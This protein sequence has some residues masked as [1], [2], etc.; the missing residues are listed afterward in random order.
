[1]KFRLFV[2]CDLLE[3]AVLFLSSS[4]V[5][6]IFNVCV[7][8]C[9]YIYI[10]MCLAAYLNELLAMFSTFISFI[11]VAEAFDNDN[12]TQHENEN[13]NQNKMNSTDTTMLFSPQSREF[14]R[15]IPPETLQRLYT[16]V[17]DTIAL[18]LRFLHELV[19]LISISLLSSLFLLCND[20]L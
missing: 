5:C 11:D 12:D 19:L 14:Y 15:Q 7:C 9:I 3:H 6:C 17:H 8:V 20:K 10:C 1:M 2:C 4:F 18:V 13:K 16:V